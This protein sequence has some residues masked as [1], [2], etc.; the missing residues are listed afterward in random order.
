M[1]AVT[2][3]NSQITVHEVLSKWPYSHPAFAKLKTKCIGCLLQKFCTLRDVAQTYQIS[4]DEL[5][6]ELEKHILT[7]NHIQRSYK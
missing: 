6:E 2:N 5:I 1:K 3:F 7:T 4:F